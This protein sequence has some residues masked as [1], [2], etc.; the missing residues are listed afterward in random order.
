[1]DLTTTKQLS[2]GENNSAS[3]S[4]SRNLILRLVTPKKFVDVVD[5]STTSY[6]IVMLTTF[7]N[8]SS[9]FHINEKAL[10]ESEALPRVRF[11]AESKIKN[12]RQTRLCR[13]RNKKLLTQK[14][15]RHR[16]F[17]T[18]SQIKNSR[19]RKNTWQRF[20]CPEQ[21]FLALGKEILKIIFL[22]PIFFFYPQHTLVQNLCSN[23]AQF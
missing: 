6:S 11:C 20:L 1:L 13:E 22:P 4:P 16:G 8:F 19:E 12:S 2:A 15:T 18:E 17:F 14:N 10:P 3:V 7:G 5:A 21:I 9:K 23:L